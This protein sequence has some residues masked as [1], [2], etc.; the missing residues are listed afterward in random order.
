MNEKLD[1]FARDLLEK[2]KAGKLDWK[3]YLNPASHGREEYYVGLGDDF[4]FNIW[5]RISGDDRT[6]TL[7]LRPKDKPG[8]IESVANNWPSLGGGVPLKES[9]T[10]FR[11]YSDLFDAVRE[12]VY[13]KDEVLDKVEEL[14]KK[15]S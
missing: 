4:S 3:R 8:A 15:I 11:L 6:I 14:L 1:Q 13:G 9:V 2:T 12:S 5:R 10:R 7:Q